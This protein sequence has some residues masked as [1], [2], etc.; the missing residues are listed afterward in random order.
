M[1]RNARLWKGVG[2]WALS[3]GALGLGNAAVLA[4]APPALARQLTDLGQQAMAQGHA[5]QARVFFRKALELDPTDAAARRGLNARSVRRVVMQAEAPVVAPPAGAP[6]TD[7]PVAAPAPADAPPGGAAPAEAPAPAGGAGVPAEAPAPGGAGVP[8]ETITETPAPPAPGDAPRPAATLEENARLGNVYRQQLIADVRQRIQEARNLLSAGQP[9]S[10][11]TVLRLAQNVIRSADQVDEAAR[12]SL[13]REVQT[14]YLATVRAEERVVAERAEAQRLSALS[15]QQ[16]RTL[17][18][19][20]RNQSTVDAMMTQ[21]GTLMAEGQYNVLFNGGMG[22]IAAATAPFYDARMLAQQARALDPPAAAPRAGMF[23]AGTMGFLAQEMAFEELKEYRFMLMMQDVTR[24][25][26]PFPDSKVIE[27]PNAESWRVLSERRIKRYGKAVD[28]LDRDPKTKSILAKLDEPVSMSF[29][30]EAPLEDVLKYIKSATQ[31]ANDQGIP[32]YVDPVGLQE[33]E[34]T[35]QSPVT[36]DLEGVPL[37]TTLRLLLKQLGMTYT[38]RDGMLTITAEASEDVP[39]EIR[40]YP[41]A[42]LAIIPISLM[43]GQGGGQ[44][45][46]MGGGGMGGGGMGGGGMGGGMGG[47]GGGMGGGG[48]M[49][50]PVQDPAGEPTSA[51]SEKKSN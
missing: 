48:M 46:G 39:T 31:G 21:F 51:Y 50:M 8:A 5:A 27:Y 49:S 13:D 30:N 29:A 26:V 20:S 43:G 4:D 14:H 33:A 6:A 35:M 7:A 11:L 44:G 37:K 34:K 12:N 15:E 45:G 25:N 28:L 2:P 23:V 47:G 10:A 17:D 9:E 32:I 40:V 19:I 24:A 18:L 16:T 1:L 3:L 42:D 36:L 22:D 41:V 38:V